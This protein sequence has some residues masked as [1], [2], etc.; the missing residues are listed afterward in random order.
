M[1]HEEL[2][3]EK[4]HAMNCKLIPGA[5]IAIFLIVLVSCSTKAPIIP[6]QG[7][8]ITAASATSQ[9]H[10]INGAFATPLAV[11]VTNNGSPA[12]GVAVSFAAPTA[13]ATGKFTDTGNT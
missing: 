12:P 11:T 7:E 9:S 2:R 10:T 8:V 4:G 6:S 1:Y 5:L 13:G 3:A